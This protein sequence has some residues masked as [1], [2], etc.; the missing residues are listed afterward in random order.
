V[1]RVFKHLKI[2]A[3][4]FVQALKMRMEYR[5]DFLVECLA[6]LMQQ[7]AGLV[8]LIFLFNNFHALKGWSQ[9]EVFFIYGFSLIPM[10]LFDA[11]ALNFYMFSDKYI[12][13]G[14]LDRLLLRPL[15]S[16]F[17]LM[18]EGIS[19]DF[20]ADLTL[21][22][23]VLS[24]AW[25]E[26]GPEWSLS[27]AFYFLGCVLGGWAVLTGVFLS[28]TSLSFWSEDRVSIMPPVYNLFNFARYPLDIYRPFIR[29]LLTWVIPFG[30]VAFYP[31]VGLLPKSLIFQNLSV[32]APAVGLCMLGLGSFI[33]WLGVRK[34]SGAGS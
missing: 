22:I 13:Q 6:A 30:F 18:I 7:T 29:I 14:E 21:G 1:A 34:Y 10:A 15:S 33:W 20:L 9:N 16:L 19:F 8:T 27:T 2:G 26:V 4:Y 12:V 24:R 17:Q 31:S 11:F 28:L 25:H 23:V 5:A 3:W 32:L